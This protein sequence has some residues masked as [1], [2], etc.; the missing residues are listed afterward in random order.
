MYSSTTNRMAPP[1]KAKKP[2]KPESVWSR[3]TGATAGDKATRKKTKAAGK[4]RKVIF[5]PA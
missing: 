4:D 2:V 5:T 1:H 3:Y